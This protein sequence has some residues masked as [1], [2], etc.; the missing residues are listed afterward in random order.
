M[1]TNNKFLKSYKN[2]NVVVTGTSGFK[3]AWLAYW[4]SNLGAKVTG[5]S[6]K[7]EKNSILFK[8]LGLKNKINQHYLDITNFYKLNEIIKKTKPDIIFHL[9]AQSIVSTSYEKPLQTFHT[10]IL[11][12]A[13]VLETYRIN[14]IPY[15]V[16]ITSDKCYLNL[17]TKKNYKEN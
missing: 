13:N 3:G 12:S 5:I 14:R 4:L 9:A 6:L 10:N 2:L 15:L 7:P 1:K 17:N 16:Y 11:G 8:S